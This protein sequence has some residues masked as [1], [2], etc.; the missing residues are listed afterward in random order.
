LVGGN[1]YLKRYV[2]E[3]SLHNNG[4]GTFTDE[5]AGAGVAY[6]EEW[7]TVAGT[8]VDFRDLDNEGAPD[9]FHTAISEIAFRFTRTWEGVNS[10]R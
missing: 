7:K 6:T 3:L 5:A 4:D 8:G 9:I 2:S 10:W 1:I